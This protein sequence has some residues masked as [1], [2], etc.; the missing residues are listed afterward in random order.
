MLFQ[1][2]QTKNVLKWEKLFNT[3]IQLQTASVT[4]RMCRMCDESERKN[5]EKE[6]REETSMHDVSCVFFF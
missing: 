4:K 5:G 2:Q 6:S 1:E 3:H